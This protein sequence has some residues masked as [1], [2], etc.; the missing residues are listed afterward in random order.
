MPRPRIFDSSVERAMP[1][2]AAA[3]DGPNTRPPLAR[4]GVFDDR[5][6][7]GGKR[8]GQHATILGGRRG[9]QPALIDSEFVRVTDDHRALDHVLQLAHITW[10]RIRA[11]AVEGSIVDPPDRLARLARV[12]ID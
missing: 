1:S 6:L 7:M 10:P 8:A 12:A 2:R 4:R 3:P 9:R 11:Q 5:S